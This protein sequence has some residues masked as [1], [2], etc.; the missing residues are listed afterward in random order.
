[1]GVIANLKT[2]PKRSEM[3]RL[4]EVYTYWAGKQFLVWCS[5]FLRSVFVFVP[6]S[7]GRPTI[8][9]PSMQ[10]L[11]NIVKMTNCIGY[12]I[13]LNMIRCCDNFIKNGSCPKLLDKIRKTSD[14]LLGQ[15]RFRFIWIKES[16]DEKLHIEFRYSYWQILSSNYRTYDSIPSAIRLL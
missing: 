13:L 2:T 14:S 6:R 10:I 16:S 15:C 8:W 9:F 5:I 7:S 12:C 3:K 1:M 4:V 11:A